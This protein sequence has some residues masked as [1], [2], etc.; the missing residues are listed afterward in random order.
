MM[1]Q[2]IDF[3][4]LGAVP[5]KKTVQK[6][7]GTPGGPD[8][9]FSDL[10][11][12]PI[13]EP[14]VMEKAI[15]NVGA[16]V[17]GL[18][19]KVGSYV[20]KYTLAPAR[21]AISTAQNADP[22]Y[23]THNYPG[24]L[25]PVEGLMSQYIDRPLKAAISQ[26]GREGAPTSKD[27]AA[28]AGLSTQES[29]LSDYAPFMYSNKPNALQMHED[30]G[31]NPQVSPAGLIGGTTEAMLPGSFNA[32][33]L[34]G[35]GAG[36]AASTVGKIPLSAT[37]D[38]GYLGEAAKSLPTT[39]ESMIA[40][41]PEKNMEV[42]KSRYGAVRDLKNASEGNPLKA[43]NELRSQIS[44]DIGDY[45]DVQNQKIQSFLKNDRSSVDPSG[46]ENKIK[47]V[48]SGINP[49]LD[50]YA[51]Q[52]LSSKLE[53]LNSVKDEHGLIPSQD[54]YQL[55]RQMRDEGSS[56]M[57]QVGDVYSKPAN[58]ALAVA[59]KRAA[60]ELRNSLGS[61]DEGLDSALKA[62]SKLHD[63]DDILRPSVLDPGASPASIY[64][65][66]SYADEPARSAL[67]QLGKITGKDYLTPA[68][69]ISAMR[70]M[71]D[72]RVD[73]HNIAK[74]IGRP[75]VKTAERLTQPGLLGDPGYWNSVRGL[76]RGSRINEQNK[77]QNHKQKQPK[78]SLVSDR[79]GSEI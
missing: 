18:L 57:T 11:A 33:G 73:S 7:G 60:G 54:A 12:V 38:I 6:V 4:D 53:T 28:K 71:Y 40:H 32:L 27:I 14:T 39:A 1:A 65:A 77:P 74:T 58:P 37:K 55:Y 72:P 26:F 68:E 44:S 30:S 19:G 9:D 48:M 69:N 29:P 51:Y 25:G 59:S 15:S 56:A 8:D 36:E 50:P 76:L 75:L 10:G 67:D 3:S 13:E 31:Y 2:N 43:S 16:P 46:A 52:D 34:L 63:V 35:K 17:A 62:H 70:S 23:A 21:A 45:K 41:V 47:E 49:K 42:F 78:G 24:A 66:G 61:I 79:E 64:R 22:Y 20:D 5:I